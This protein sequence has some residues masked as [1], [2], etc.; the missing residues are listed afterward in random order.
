MMADQNIDETQP[1]DTAAELVD[2]APVTS[3][4][5]GRSEHASVGG[6]RN[7]ARDFDPTSRGDENG[8]LT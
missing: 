7:D 4:P 5:G 8:E 2:D 1:G 6:E 3:R